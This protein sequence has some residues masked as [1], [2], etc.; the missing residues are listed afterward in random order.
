M[1]PDTDSLTLILDTFLDAFS[2]GRT[3]VGRSANSLLAILATLEILMAAIWWSITGSDVVVKFLKK[4]LLIGFFIW[5]VE[6]WDSL[7]GTVIAG[8]I[9]TGENAGASAGGNIVSLENPSAIV[10]A[11][12][13]AVLPI[14]E[15]LRSFDSYFSAVSNPIDLIIALIACV[16]IIGSFFVLAIQVFITRLEFGLMATLG[17]ILIPFGVFRHTAF[18]SEKV[19]GALISFGIKLMMLSFIISITFPIL[20]QF[21]VPADPSWIEMLNMVLVSMSVMILS[22]HAPSVATGLLSGSPNLSAR[23][24][25]GASMTASHALSQIVKQSGSIGSSTKGATAV[26]SSATLSTVSTVGKV[27]SFGAGMAVGAYNSPGSTI[28]NFGERAFSVGK[29]VLSSSFSQEDR[30]SKNSLRESFNSGREIRVSKGKMQGEN[31]NLSSKE[32]ENISPKSKEDTRN[33]QAVKSLKTKST[34]HRSK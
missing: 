18:L 22:W 10:D 1:T 17:L 12:F 29:E 23:D 7:V 30:T 6:S 21:K 13:N 27:A 31:Q 4:V 26:A 15:H 32:Q 33:E 25:S 28:K 3:A 11:G 16:L 24:V 20:I 14:F 8:F 19:F 2:L 9:Y 34:N 5:I